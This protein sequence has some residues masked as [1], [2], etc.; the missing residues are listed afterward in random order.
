MGLQ[1]SNT[2]TDGGADAVG[3]HE[4]GGIGEFR[5]N[6]QDR[7]LQFGYRVFRGIA[8]GQDIAGIFAFACLLGLYSLRSLAGELPV[9]WDAVP[10]SDI[11]GYRVYY[12]TK[13]VQVGRRF[14]R[15]L[16]ASTLEGRTPYTEAYRLLS[17]KKAKTFT[18]LG[19]RTNWNLAAPA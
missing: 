11:A 8:L 9:L 17:I 14:A 6:P 2:L 19:E 10:Q 4:R 3:I 18:N 1:R 7:R 5:F 16:V 15:A 13:P 12:N